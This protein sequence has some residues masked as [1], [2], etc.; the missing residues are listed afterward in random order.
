MTE[1]SASAAALKELKTGVLVQKQGWGG[2]EE[3]LLQ[4]SSSTLSTIDPADGRIIQSWGLTDVLSVRSAP[5]QHPLRARARGA[6]RRPCSPQP[7]A[8]VATQVQL[9]DAQLKLRLVS[10]ACLSCGLCSDSLQLAC[11]SG[12]R[13]STLRDGIALACREIAPSA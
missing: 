6:T 7:T 4:L 10:S 12:T 9:D 11:T 1:T 2:E 5:S 13:A 3:T 8:A